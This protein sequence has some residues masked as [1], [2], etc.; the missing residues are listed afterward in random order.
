M[1]EDSP[2]APDR[3]EDI[4]P[5]VATPPGRHGVWLFAGGLLIAALL[6]FEALEARRASLTAPATG[7]PAGE[8]AA[9]IG[10]PPELTIPDTAPAVSAPWASW[11]QATVPRPVVIAP[12]VTTV[13]AGAT[14]PGRR[15]GHPAV[16]A[17]TSPVMPA[18][19]AGWPAPPMAAAAP[20]PWSPSGNSG[21]SAQPAPKPTG[22]DKDRVRAAQFENPS[23]TVPKGTVVQAV[24][25]SALDSTRA[26]FARAIVARDV[27]SFDGSRVV[28]QRGSRLT[29]EYKSDVG[30]GQSR[31]L[32]QW[33][34]LMRPDGVMIELDSPSADPLG[35]AGIKGSVN[36][37]FFARF[38]GAILQ[39][40]LQIG[41]QLATRA[42]TKDAYILAL[43]G[44]MPNVTG[45]VPDKIA[46]TVK[47]R[48]GTSVSVFV[49]RDLDFTGF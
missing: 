20:A 17:P 28:I 1:S 36:T 6:L 33:Q 27:W 16:L 19:A 24:L 18:P 14:T 22:S 31:V 42:A 39:S 7:I 30:A 40:A 38:G 9:S 49:A 4:R 26:G 2:Q 15:T 32:I 47:V 43:P 37:H 10:S 48:Q 29:G 25:E 3:H 8:P 41:E 12:P 5:V 35:R 45:F 13:I 46:P 21:P 34:R 11:P 44:S 23:T